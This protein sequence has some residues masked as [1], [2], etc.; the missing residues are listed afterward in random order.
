MNIFLADALNNLD[1]LEFDSIS[2]FFHHYFTWSFWEKQLPLIGTFI[3]RVI[4]AIVVYI[5]A[6]KLIHKLCRFIVASMKKA[7][8]DTGVTQFVSSVVR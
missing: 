1:T 8:V 3:G 7:N 2:D 5:V 4:L 6:S